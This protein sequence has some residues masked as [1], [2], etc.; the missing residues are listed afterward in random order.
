MRQRKLTCLL[1]FRSL[2]GQD[3]GLT[4]IKVQVPEE[5]NFVKHYLAVQVIFSLIISFSHAG[6][7]SQKELLLY[8]HEYYLISKFRKKLSVHELLK[9]LFQAITVGYKDRISNDN[10]HFN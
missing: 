4:T 5:L 3:A 6:F 2:G 7:C 9:H 8:F 1:S 10:L